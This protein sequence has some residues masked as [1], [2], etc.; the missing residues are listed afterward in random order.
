MAPA[1]TVA[2]GRTAV[3]GAGPLLAGM[4]A[5]VVPV[6]ASMPVVAAGSGDTPEAVDSEAVERLWGRLHLA[7]TVRPG[8]LKVGL[9]CVYHVTFL[10][11]QWRP[12]GVR[13][14]CDL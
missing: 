1:G 13:F 3:P 5:L 4:P 9:S 2:P 14:S 6:V 7:A 10:Q 11:N 12:C 8:I